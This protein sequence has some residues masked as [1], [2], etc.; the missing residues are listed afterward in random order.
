MNCAASIDF[1]FFFFFF[2]FAC[3]ACWEQGI[4]ALPF[5]IAGLLS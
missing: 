5:A 2:G 4:H 3:E 1:L